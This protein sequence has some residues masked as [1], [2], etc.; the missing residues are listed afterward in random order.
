[1]ARKATPGTPGSVKFNLKDGNKLLTRLDLPRLKALLTRLFPNAQQIQYSP[2]GVRINCVATPVTGHIDNSPSM[3]FD[4]QRGTVKCKACQY[5]TRNILQ[6]LQDSKGFSYRDGMAELVTITGVRLVSEKV[7]AELEAYEVHTLALQ[8]LLHAC[9][10]YGLKL[11]APPQGDTED[12]RDYDELT[13]HAAGP[14]LDWLFR[15]RGH[16]PEYMGQLPYGIV[17]P[18]PIINRYVEQRLV[19]LSD[20][21]YRRFQTTHLSPERREKVLA[22]VKTILEPVTTEWTNTVAFFNG[23]TMRTPARVRLRRPDVN[24]EKDNNYLTLPGY[25]EE[26]PLGYFGLYAPHLGGLTP[27]EGQAIRLFLVEGENDTISAQ[28]RLFDR[29]MT[30]QLFIGSNGAFNELDELCTAGFDSVNIMSDH[31]SESRG[32]GDVWLRGR[33]MT[34]QEIAP[35]IFMGWP[36]LDRLTPGT[37]KDP[38]DVIQLGGF[39]QFKRLVIDD[40][41]RTFVP[42]DSWAMDRALEAS[43]GI[44]PDEV[45]EKTAVAVKFGECVRDA[46]QLSQYIDKICASL[47]ITPS[48]VRS[49]IVRSKDDEAGFISRFVDLYRREF[50]VL[51][52][53][54]SMRGGIMF[55]HHR[56]TDRTIMF[57]MS[58]GE[59]ILTSL[60]NVV[61]DIHEFVSNNVGIP[62][63]LLP[64]TQ[65]P[66][67]QPIRELQKVL[68]MYAKIAL[69]SVYQGVPSKSECTFLGQGTHLIDD[70]NVPFGQYFYVVNGSSVYKGLFALDASRTVNWVKLDGPSDATYIFSRESA[71]VCAEIQSVADLNEGN[72]ISLEELGRA[73]DDV[74]IAVREG[75]STLST[76]LDAQYVAYSLFTYSSPHFCPST[77]HLEIVGQMSSGKSTLLSLY[78]G[79]QYPQLQLCAWAKGLLNYSPA[80]IYQGFNASTIAMCLDEHTRDLAM[81]TMKTMQVQNVNELLR[82]VIF[83]GGAVVTRGDQDGQTRTMRVRTNVATSSIFPAHDAQ[84]ASRRYTIETVKVEGKKDPTTVINQYIPQE[85]LRRIKRIFALASFHYQR[86]YQDHYKAI[87]KELSSASMV[88]SYAVDTRFLRNFYAI[89]AVMALLGRDWRAFVTQCAESRK[90]RMQA[91]S[92][93]TLANQ[94]FDTIFRTNNVRV[95]SSGV[96]SAAALL[97]SKDGRAVALNGSLCGVFYQ[98]ETG[99]MVFDWITLLSPNGIL[100]RSEA[101]NKASPQLLKYQLDQHH[102]ALR[103]HEYDV[104]AVTD[105]LRG[106]S[107]HSGGTDISVLEMKKIVDELREHAVARPVENE[108][109]RAAHGDGPPGLR[110]INNF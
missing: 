25:T 8:T 110:S 93:N 101:F 47:G 46:A 18:K 16:K 44:A 75:W 80:S 2:Y 54:D 103:E 59:G 4:V 71:A 86:D 70:P 78:C 88:F 23:H 83:P 43:S 94:L 61:G 49:L 92:K 79:G 22:R 68:S 19:D 76:A 74:E 52:K 26:E 105:W 24:D 39:D 42:V 89:G 99:Y 17:P 20:A 12:A 1:M 31:P 51:Y 77:T 109:P 10:Q 53:E 85:R 108:R 102:A 6:L 82:Q 63:W 65:T 3:Y 37:P 32:K 41:A 27:A 45:R 90:A 15:Q 9:S 107:V 36:E 33:L 30:N 69:Q 34:A 98:E 91:N 38:D 56:A 21:D 28:E 14:V 96:S 84:D 13:R 58:D 55:L 64:Q 62:A 106:Y 100:H 11:L 35:R 87:E 5:F 67:G 50:H 57:G 73:I 29:G 95:G 40:A 66:V 7:E 97:G 48:V 81:N 60:S 72:D 104:K